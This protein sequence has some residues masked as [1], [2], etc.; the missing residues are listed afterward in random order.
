MSAAR[1]VGG[2]RERTNVHDGP[3]A[4]ARGGELY[5]AGWTI[6]VRDAAARWAPARAAAMHAQRTVHVN[7]LEYMYYTAVGS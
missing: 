7:V 5:A 3:D 1:V 4:A 2:V 6:V